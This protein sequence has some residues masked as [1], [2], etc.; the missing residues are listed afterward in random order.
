MIKQMNELMIAVEGNRKDCSALAQ[1]SSEIDNIL[2][3]FQNVESL[4]LTL[5]TFS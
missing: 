5:H 4:Y 2:T 1:G 3:V